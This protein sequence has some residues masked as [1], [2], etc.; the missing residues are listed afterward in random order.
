VSR[1]RD[2]ASRT[3]NYVV[4]NATATTVNSGTPTTIA[5]VTITT[6]GRAVL[7]VASGDMNPVAATW[8]YTQLYRGETAIGKYIINES[9]STSANSPFSLTHVDVV[10]AGTY[11]YTVRANQG[12]AGAAQYG[13]TGNAQAPT[14]VALELG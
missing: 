11:T 7:L 14:L 12:G 4:S 13:E 3:P 10:A 1:S 6:T 8:N 9:T 5:S 2:A